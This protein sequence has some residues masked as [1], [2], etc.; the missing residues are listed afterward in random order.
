MINLKPEADDHYLSL[1][2]TA[3]RLVADF[4]CLN[5]ETCEAVKETVTVEREEIESR[6][7]GD[8][9][10]VLEWFAGTQKTVLSNGNVH[11]ELNDRFVDWYYI[12]DQQTPEDLYSE[13]KQD[14]HHD[15][16]LVGWVQERVGP[17]FDVKCLTE[18][19]ADQDDYTLCDGDALSEE[20]SS[21]GNPWVLYG[22]AEGTEY[23]NDYIK[24]TSDPDFVPDYFYPN[25]PAELSW[26]YLTDSAPS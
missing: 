23:R 17:Q 9:S 21:I 6:Y 25:E 2:I 12:E 10:I 16:A 13:L 22:G 15:H 1:T 19:E 8:Y 26:I 4:T 24:I 7:P 5:H 14:P 20:I 11:L 3:Q 18:H